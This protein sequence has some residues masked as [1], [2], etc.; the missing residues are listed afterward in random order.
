MAQRNTAAK[1]LVITCIKGDGKFLK[2][3]ALTLNGLE[4]VKSFEARL[5]SLTTQLDTSAGFSAPEQIPL[6]L[7]CVVKSKVKHNKW[8]RAVVLANQSYNAVLVRL[9][10]YGNEEAASILDIRPAND[11]IMNA[12][13]QAIECLLADVMPIRN[14][15]SPEAINFCE[16][17][18]LYNTLSCFVVS[19]YMKIP[20]VRVAKKGESE[21]FVQRLINGGLALIKRESV[22][23]PP[24]ALSYKLNQLEINSKHLVRV[25]C[26]ENPHK[27]FV[28]LS[29]AEMELKNLMDSLSRVPTENFE[30]LKVAAAN[31][32]CLAQ[33]STKPCFYRGLITFFQQRKCQVF[34]VDYGFSELKDIAELKVIPPPFLQLSAQAIC[35]SL[36]REATID[37]EEF[38]QVIG[39]QHLELLVLS[40]INEAYIVKLFRQGHDLLMSPPVPQNYIQQ[41]I[42]LGTK[43]EVVVSYVNDLTEFYCQLAQLKDQQSIISNI[44]NSGYPFIPISFCE[45]TPGRPVCVKFSEDGLWYR[46]RIIKVNHESDIEVF[47]VD[48]GNYDN[49]NVNDVRKIGVD[50]LK[51]PVQA[52]KC[53]LVGVTVPTES[54]ARDDAFDLLE[55]LTIDQDL[56][57]HV[58]LFSADAGYGITLY[59]KNSTESVNDK[60]LSK[61]LSIAT[62]PV[63]DVE[64]VYVTTFESPS[65]FFVQ[66]EKLDSEKLALMQEEIN[67]FY[68]G[69]LNNS[70][71]PQEGNLVCARFNEDNQFYRAKVESCKSGYC[72]VY[73]IDYGNR[74]SIPLKDVH[75]MDEKF[76]A[77]PQF[78]TECAF[79]NFKATVSADKLSS[80]LL[81][82]SIQIKMIRKDNGKWFVSLGEHFPGNVAM[83]ELMRQADAPVPRSIHGKHFFKVIYA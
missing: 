82:N 42:T 11:Q 45:C 64:N 56:Y 16:H 10:D 2:F 32:P 49:V 65:S 41:K 51:F 57:A 31:M 37:P 74:E 36:P 54:T 76:T 71:V 66:F 21:A 50:L 17:H 33:L 8:C 29:A 48:F 28:Q 80:L 9:L 63:N 70:F 55:S 40:Q 81:E 12:P 26:I 69:K 83:L 15:W 27:F 13:P 61:F 58:H 43:C 75:S 46:A 24:Q 47:F 30:P 60:M 39:F 77:Y 18:L 6:N 14:E 67:A 5:A 73:F 3:W 34:F 20:V 1:D 35:C 52:F 62:V 72:S 44:L 22:S 38:K 19:N 68:S 79:E 53:F 78:G 7:K 25:A 59:M 4:T 23:P